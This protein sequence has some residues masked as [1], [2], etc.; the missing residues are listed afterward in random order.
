MT[1]LV[2]FAAYCA[3]VAVA[4]YFGYRWGRATAP[5]A[6][7]IAELRLMLVQSQRNAE[8]AWEARYA[9]G[10]ER[11][12]VD[13][14]ELEAAKRS[15]SATRGAATRRNRVT[16]ETRPAVRP[17]GAAPIIVPDMGEEPE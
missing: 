6:Q 5:G 1:P 9:A 10:Y 2:Y 12:R 4:L 3:S 7:L 17:M 14:A 16:G 15:E 13:Q 11:G 8:E